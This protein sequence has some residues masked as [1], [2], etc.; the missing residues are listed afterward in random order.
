VGRTGTEIE[1]DVRQL[2]ARAI[3]DAIR[4]TIDD[5]GPAAKRAWLAVTDVQEA[6]DSEGLEV[7]RKHEPAG[8]ALGE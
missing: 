7:F 3:H 4:R 6:F 5:D 2:A 8:A 1:K